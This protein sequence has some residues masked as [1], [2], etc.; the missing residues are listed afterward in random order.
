MEK[1]KKIHIDCNLSVVGFLLNKEKPNE[2]TTFPKPGALNLEP[3]EYEFQYDYPLSTTAKFKHKLTPK[4]SGRNIL[5]YAARD[6]KKIYDIEDGKAGDPGYIKG[7]LNRNESDGPFGIWG[8]YM[9]DL[10]FEGIHIDP[11]KKIVRFFMGS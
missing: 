10:F 1:N 8:H 11:A 9:G 6:Y 2:Y 7:M 3:G 4:T 5:R